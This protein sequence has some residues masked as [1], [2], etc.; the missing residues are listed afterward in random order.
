MQPL[1]LLTIEAS[2][3]SMQHQSASA[4]SPGLRSSSLHPPV[5]TRFDAKLISFAVLPRKIV[6]L[7][8]QSD[9][10]DA[11]ST[12][13]LVQDDL[14]VV[15]AALCACGKHIGNLDDFIPAD[16][17][18]LHRPVNIALLRINRLFL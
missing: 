11:L 9:I 7:F 2:F 14:L 8:R 18:I 6:A 5:L 4:T 13:V 1:D 17:S 16:G 3:F 12:L 10:D 15:G